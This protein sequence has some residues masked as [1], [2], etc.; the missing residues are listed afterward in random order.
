MLFSQTIDNI[1]SEITAL[2][3]RV[4]VAKQRQTQL[5]ELDA[6][7]DHTLEGLA[8]VVSKIQCSA[9]DAIASLKTAVLT[10]FDDGDD[11][12][13]GRS[14]S[15][16]SS[17]GNQPHEPTPEPDDSEFELLCLN[18]ET[19][20][21]L[22]TDDLTDAD[23]EADTSIKLTYSQ[24]IKN[25]CGACW[26]YEVKS[27]TDIKAGFVNRANLNFMEA[28]N[29]E[30]TGKEFYQTV[31]AYLNRLYY[32]GQTCELASLLE[33]DKPLVAG[34]RFW[35]G[36]PDNT[37]TVLE[38][39][40]NGEYKVQI[41]GAVGEVT[42]E[43]HRLH[44]FVE[45]L[46]GQTCDIDKAPLTG[47]HCTIPFSSAEVAYTE[48]VKVGDRIG[49]IKINTTGEIIATY[50]GFNNKTR[51]KSWAN[52]LETMTSRIELRA[53]KRLG[54]WKHELK[55]SG[56]SIKQIE[57][58]AA[59]NLDKMPPDK[60]PSLPPTYKPQPIPQPVN[61]DEV[62]KDDIV[63]ALLTPSASYKIIQVMPNGILDCENLTSGDRLGLRPGAVSLVQ[64]AEKF[65]QQTLDP[66]PKPDAP[67]KYARVKLKG[68]KF[69]GQL[70]AVV[71]RNELGATLA[72]PYGHHWFR[73]D[74]LQIIDPDAQT[75]TGNYKGLSKQMR[76]HW[77][78]VG[79]N[80]SDLIADMKANRP[81][82]PEWDAAKYNPVLA[83]VGADDASDF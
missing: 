14:A 49:Y 22:T 36:A 12:S 34:S 33:L 23:I 81:P 10:L 82:A 30:R 38:S 1:D 32:N 40:G 74:C 67:T 47:Q 77:E 83:A 27:K 13:D 25:R 20:D 7:T 4:E 18:G 11:G 68:D 52:Y 66:N 48:F 60:E 53:A 79:I 19:G 37:G 45:S 8:D 71:K 76:Q 59:E 73:S 26:G 80:P 35:F 6:L 28:V 46:T 62:G 9:P 21:C 44:Y 58:I 2:L 63:T 54:D 51:A 55:M 65:E 61:P 57:R 29:L 69:D 31:E 43:R 24:A 41:D 75:T 15:A 78:K 42:L 5:I 50:A 72:T 56:L 17:R 64:K 39:A 70:F 3:A 16:Q